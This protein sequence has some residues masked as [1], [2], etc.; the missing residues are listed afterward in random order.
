MGNI[1]T[2]FISEFTPAGINQTLHK[3]FMEVTATVHIIIP[4]AENKVTTI[5]QVLIEESIII[6]KIPDVYLGTQTADVTYN[7]V[8]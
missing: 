3:L 7:L 2:N 6:G 4:G 5:T 8:P 1:D